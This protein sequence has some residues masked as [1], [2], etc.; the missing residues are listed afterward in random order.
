MK[1]APRT[2]EVV[3]GRAR[4][5]VPLYRDAETTREIAARVNERLEEIE[6]A[7]GRVDTQAFALIAAYMFAADEDRMTRERGE[8]TQE[9]LVR[10]DKVCTALRGLA[11]ETILPESD[12]RR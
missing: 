1:E 8:E 9:L 3:L 6:E 4:V 7:T 10:L 12:Q 11:D 5:S 2:V